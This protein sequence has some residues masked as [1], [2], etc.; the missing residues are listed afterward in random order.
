M[1]AGKHKKIL[2]HP[3]LIKWYGQNMN[4]ISNKS[5]GIPIG[6]ENKYWKRT[7]IEVIKHHSKK[8]ICFD[9][10]IDFDGLG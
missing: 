3:L 1:E 6:L 2:N 5:E 10:F 8:S 4:I 9:M 7:N